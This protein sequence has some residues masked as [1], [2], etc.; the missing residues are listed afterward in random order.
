MKIDNIDIQ[1]IYIE[2][3][4]I[5]KYKWL[6]LLVYMGVIFYVIE[7]ALSLQNDIFK[8]M[9]FII[10]AI[11]L[12]LVLFASIKN[13]D[14]IHKQ[15][16]LLNPFQKQQEQLYE[17]FILFSLYVALLIIFYMPVTI[18]Y[19]T[20]LSTII[21]NLLTSI[22]GEYLEYIL[23][24]LLINAFKI[25]FCSS[26][27]NLISYKNEALKSFTYGFKN[28]F[29]FRRIILCFSTID[30]LLLTLAKQEYNNLKYII[31]FLL[32]FTPVFLFLIFFSFFNIKQI[33]TQQ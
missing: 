6:L 22:G 31:N 8:Q 14:P 1:K 24:I 29:T 17:I 12:Y 2:S 7:H 3:L 18:I 32:Y 15:F 23:L 26:M 28:I 9:A 5:L 27:A 10:Y 25:L 4:Q 21:N 13:N 20:P 33:S 19:L 16:K 11:Y 30:L